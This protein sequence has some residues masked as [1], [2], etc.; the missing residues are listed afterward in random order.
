MG[1]H[2]ELSP[3]AADPSAGNDSSSGTELNEN[4]RVELRVTYSVNPPQQPA[5]PPATPSP[6]KTTTQPGIGGSGTEKD[7]AVAVAA[8]VAIENVTE[9]L[10]PQHRSEAALSS[11]P[12]VP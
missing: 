1:W 12:K 10:I 3:D 11:S 2:G 8:A 7:G 4:R 9:L 6:A 5:P